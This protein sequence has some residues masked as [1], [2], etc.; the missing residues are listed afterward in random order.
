MQ[1]EAAKLIAFDAIAF[2][3]SH[4]ELKDRFLSLSGLSPA[5]IKNNIESVEFLESILDFFIQFEPDL[6]ALADTIETTP[7]NIIDAWRSLGGGKGQE[8]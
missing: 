6:I 3:F 2:L 5:E 4:D 7:V 8:W 1:I